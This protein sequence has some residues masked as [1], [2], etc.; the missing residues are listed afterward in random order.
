MQVIY[1]YIRETNYVPRE[2]II[3]II[4]IILKSQIKCECL[5][6]LLYVTWRNRPEAVTSS[7]WLWEP[8]ILQIKC[9]HEEY[10]SKSLS[11]IY[12]ITIV[13]LKIYAYDIAEPGGRPV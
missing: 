1:A 10:I 5:S 4:I 2:Y 6:L 7:T 12:L 3:I 9:G 13:N 11:Y 8:Q